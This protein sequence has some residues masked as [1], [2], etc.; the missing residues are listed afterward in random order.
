MSRVHGTIPK[1]DSYGPHGGASAMLITL[2]LIPSDPSTF[3]EGVWRHSFV[4]L[5]APSAF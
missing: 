2:K 1:G 5:E 3:S 4:G